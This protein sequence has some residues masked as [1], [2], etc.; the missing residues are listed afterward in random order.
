[1]FIHLFS[2]DTLICIKNYNQ[3][4]LK[5]KLNVIFISKSEWLCMM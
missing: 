2:C 4:S 5:I 1:M 3:N